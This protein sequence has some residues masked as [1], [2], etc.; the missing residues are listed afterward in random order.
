MDTIFGGPVCVIASMAAKTCGTIMFSN[1]QLGPIACPSLKSYL[2]ASLCRTNFLHDSMYG[3]LACG[4]VVLNCDTSSMAANLNMECFAG[5]QMVNEVAAGHHV[6]MALTPK[7][8]HM[9]L[10]NYF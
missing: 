9:S 10:Q 2:S 5:Y 4:H 3:V 6:T 7:N 8:R 1:L